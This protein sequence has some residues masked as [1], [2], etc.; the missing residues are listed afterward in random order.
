[1]LKQTG[2]GE[3]KKTYFKSSNWRHQ[4]NSAKF[5]T[6]FF[7]FYGGG[8]QGATIPGQN[9]P[10]SDVQEGVL[11]IP[12]SSS[13]TEASPSDGLMSYLGHLGGSYPSTEM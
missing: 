7:S 11:N 4:R 1:M 10:K 2:F 12:Q 3:G 6:F 13:V 8:L 9:G 5:L